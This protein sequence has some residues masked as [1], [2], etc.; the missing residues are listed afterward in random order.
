MQMACLTFLD[1]ALMHRCYLQKT[2]HMLK[3]Y[4]KIALRN[5]L[6]YK[7]YSFINIM[8]LAIS[9]ASSIL[10][11]LWVLNEL[12]YDRFHPKADRIYRITCYIED[13][14][15]AVNPAAMPVTLK[16]EI[17]A[18]QEFV[19]ISS[20]ETILFQ[21]GDRKFEEKNVLYVDSSFFRVFSFPL[22]EG[23]T[24][25]ALERKDAVLI[26]QDMAK[27]YFGKEDPVGKT[28]RIRNKDYVTV[29]G[30]LKNVPA[31]SH[32]QFD[33]LMPMI[34]IAETNNDIK[35]NKWDNFNFYSYLLM[36][37]S[38]EPS[39]EHLAALGNQM[40]QIY[41]NNEKQVKVAFQ[42]QPLTKIHLYS[43]LQAD[44]SGH[45]NIQYVNIFF[46]VAIFILVVACINFMNLATARSSRRAK[47][48][49]LRKAIGAE[50]KQLIAQF[51][52]ES[53]VIS[54]VAL[55]VAIGL[56]FLCLP[57]FNN[58][59]GKELNIRFLSGKLWLGLIGLA[60]VTG[61][62]S[63]SY[64]ALFLSGFQPVKVL[65]GSLKS[66]TG[67]TIFRHTLV[68]TQ[69]IV[70]ILL[71]SGTIVVYKQLKFMRSRDLGFEKEN[72]LYMPMTGDMWGKVQALKAELKKNS[73]TEDFVFAS[74]L[75]ANLSNGTIS[76]NW[77]GKDPQQQVIFPNMAVSENFVD[78]FKMKILAG[79]GFS[80]SFRG[81]SASFIVNETAL[82]VMGK[83][84]SEA[85]GQ[86]FTL[87]ETKGTIIGVVKDFNYK[88]IQQ[89]IEPLVMRLNNW[90][91]YIVVKTKPGKTEATISALRTISTDL[92]PNYPFS[93]NF[94]DQ[95]IANLYKGEQQLGIL[96]NIFAGLGIFISCLGLYGLSA[97][98]A[99]QRT[100][101]IGVRKVLGASVF[102]IVYLLSTGVTKLIL[103]AALIAIP[104]SW[105]A[106]NNWLQGFAYHIN[107]GWIIF[108]VSAL[109]AL[110]IAWLTV[111]YE[112]VKAALA[113]PVKS[114]K[115]E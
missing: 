96:F 68:I 12:S 55:I 59:T 94:L 6:R 91:G 56:V 4:F 45:G 69:F 8:G 106:I 74:D 5:L 32:L 110:L 57:L 35:E 64:P 80:E 53:L 89:P 100:K 60:L 29:T 71:L 16:K 41:K 76:V 34:A 28:L 75:P 31:N 51:L 23:N 22:V 72:L 30:V 33:F 36:K 98:I 10:I 48:V 3:N 84:L 85:V 50:R 26:T 111:S 17:P 19:R 21:S 102:S 11:L 39:R 114:L 108:A 40:T 9:M 43:R 54:F 42:L 2:P 49:G 24:K 115:I 70:S 78:V 95:D 77:E 92:N 47:E 46:I 101:E 1:K 44:I 107:P 27:K 112:S 67:N 37:E 83:K 105:F 63:G 103:I 79:R 81:D 93:Y 113:N 73:L 86:P 18:I 65:K 90:G 58:V 82:K 97:F 99:E 15:A 14:K 52:G 20:P 104:L 38:F 109:S 66:F 25:T 87:W 62:L 13:F 61:L 88:P 7:A